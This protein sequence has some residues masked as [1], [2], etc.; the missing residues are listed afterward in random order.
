MFAAGL[1]SRWG[2]ARQEA[3]SPDIVVAFFATWEALDADQIAQT[4][5]DDGVHENMTTSN[6]IQGRGDVRRSLVHVLGAFSNAV[7]ERI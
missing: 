7:V 3:D 1:T 2:D 5:A 6:I 4:Y